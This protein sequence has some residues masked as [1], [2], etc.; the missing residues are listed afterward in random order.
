MSASYYKTADTAAIDTDTYVQQNIG[1]TRLMTFTVK[2]FYN[3]ISLS[4]GASCP[5]TALPLGTCKLEF[6][7]AFQNIKTITLTSTTGYIEFSTPFLTETGGRS[8]QIFLSCKPAAPFASCAEAQVL[9]DDVTFTDPGWDCS[10]IPWGCFTDS[11]SFR[12][13][14]AHGILHNWPLTTTVEACA[15][16]C[17]N[18]GFTYAGL[19]YGVEC[20]CGNGISSSPATEGC[21]MPCSGNP[22]QICGGP[23]RLSVYHK[24]G[25]AKA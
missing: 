4:K 10:W 15:D 1:A 3:V 8:I 13:L 18:Q 14:P 17:H 7:Y 25:I 5:D 2:A 21:D 11:T 9:L 12:A 16:A 20:W 24:I 19:E 6:T 23:D 22:A